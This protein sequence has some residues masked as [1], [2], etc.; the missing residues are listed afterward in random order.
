MK[1]RPLIL[2]PFLLF[3]LSACSANREDT[4]SGVIPDGAPLELDGAV[5]DGAS[6]DGAADAALPTD[7]S[8]FGFTIRDRSPAAGLFPEGY[9]TYAPQG[10]ITAD[11][12]VVVFLEGG[13]SGPTID[14]Y[15]G[16]MEFMASKGYFVIGA[17]SGGSYDSTLADG[18][19]STAITRA[20]E[21]HGLDLSK[22]AVMGHSQGGGQAFY[23]MR[24]LQ[25]RGYGS[26]ASLVLS[27]DG[28]FSFSANQADIQALTGDIAFLQMNGL[29]GTGT[30]PRIALTIWSLASET[31]RN[32][33][34][35]PQNN[36]SYVAGDVANITEKGD[37]LLMLGAMLDDTFTG[38]RA[39]FAAI[40]EQNKATY[41]EVFGALEP[42]NTYNAGDCA[43]ADYNAY[44]NQLKFNDIEYCAPP[45]P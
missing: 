6:P 20:V 27:I 5:A 1:T 8:S 15:R 29:L 28:W 36:H 40:P 11:M 12:P 2:V 14:D 25:Q 26:E 23:V 44:E 22:L 45:A 3:A 43:G 17:E 32:Y 34:T 13:G 37:L 7:Y 38:R 42:A 9:V 19:V 39:G 4:P 10:Q 41:A 35:L 16:A 31:N 21:A 33:L 24:Q 18:I 30:D